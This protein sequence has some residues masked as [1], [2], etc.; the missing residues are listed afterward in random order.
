MFHKRVQYPVIDTAPGVVE[1]GWYHNDDLP[2][3]I[4]WTR[5]RYVAPGMPY[6]GASGRAAETATLGVAET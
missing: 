6:P 1:K 2:H 4:S 5:D 3:V